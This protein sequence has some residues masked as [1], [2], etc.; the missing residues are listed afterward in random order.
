MALTIE[1]YEASKS[2]EWDK[3]VLYDSMNGTFL[4]SRKFIEY[5]SKDRFKDVSLCVRKGNELV[6]TILACEINEGERYFF[7]HKGSTYGGFVVSEKIYSATGIN[8]LMDIFHNFIKN[9]GFFGIY[10]KMLPSVYQR[11]NTDLLDYFLYKNGY[12]CYSELNYFMKLDRYRQDLL[13]QFS[14]N[15]RR[16]YRYSLK[17]NLIFREITEKEGI[18]AYYEVL[19]MNLKKL[20]LT[21][22]HSLEDLLDLKFN[23][24]NDNIKF[25]GVYLE[26]KLV[27]GSM[28]F[29][30]D[31]RIFHT[32]YLSSDEEYLKLYTMDFLITNLIMA[33]LEL[34]ME[35]FTFGICTEDQGRYLN[36]GLSRF[37]EGF[38]VE[39]E[40]NRSYERKI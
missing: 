29:I 37:K 30:F 10:L 27:A 24:F 5:H 17:N 16:D 14:K 18:A 1:Y 20:N 13:S 3:F 9:E 35:T 6:A 23:R 19:L 8:E 31:N 28:I 36:L 33:A 12:F 7:S 34:N 39:F 4:Q 32:Q 15:K 21:P 25:Y 11:K 26:D 22:V 40:I 2:Q 38:G